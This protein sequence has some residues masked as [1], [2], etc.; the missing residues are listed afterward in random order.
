MKAVR[1][2]LAAALILTGLVGIPVSLSFGDTKLSDTIRQA[3]VTVCTNTFNLCTAHCSALASSAPNAY[4]G[5]MQDCAGQYARCMGAIA[6]RAPKS[7]LRGSV[8]PPPVAPPKPT[9]RKISP[10]RVGGV[11]TTKG[12]PTI[13]PQRSA[14]SSTPVTRLRSSKA[15]ATPTPNPARK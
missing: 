13:S 7:D 6:R 10:E 9:P 2:S 15:S 1:V 8:S 12:A 3:Q 5:C 14:S 11:S 4:P